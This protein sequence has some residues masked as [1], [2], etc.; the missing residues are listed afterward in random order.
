MTDRALKMIKD[1]EFSNN[2]AN[3]LHKNPTEDGLTYYGIYEKAHPNW[4][5]WGIIKRYLKIEPN[6][7][8]CSLAL[9]NNRELEFMVIGFYREE[10][11]NKLKLD[12]V[13]SEDKQIE[14]LCFA[15]NVGIKP[16]V[17]TLQMLLGVTVDGI[18]GKNT[19]SALNGFDDELFDK[20]F[21]V[22]EKEYYD[23]L[24]ANKPSYIIYKKGW[25]NRADKY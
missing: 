11:W 4:N 25:H 18:I 21:D 14:I 7:K 3:L 9:S 10:F 12:N 20:L 16:C 19:L 8:K 1:V 15:I 17:K 6:L 23:K 13:E 22:Y 24:I 5:G 2:N